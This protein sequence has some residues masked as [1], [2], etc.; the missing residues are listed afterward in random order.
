MNERVDSYQEENEFILE[1]LS[2]KNV[3]KI[4]L[5]IDKESQK[6]GYSVIRLDKKESQ[7]KDIYDVKNTALQIVTLSMLFLSSSLL[8]IICFWMSQYDES[9]LVYYLLGMKGLDPKISVYF[10]LIL[11][12]GY[13]GAFI[14]SEVESISMGIF[15]FT[16]LFIF[17]MSAF[18]GCIVYKR[19]GAENEKSMDRNFI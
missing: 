12:F 2:F 4:F 18:L 1:G 7:L 9:R 3:E 19:K 6:E 11:L 5:H 15:I 16:I 10:I 13:A 17:N 8:L 14:C